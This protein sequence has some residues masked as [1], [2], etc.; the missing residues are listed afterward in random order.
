MKN[1][2]LNVRISELTQ[3]RLN[4]LMEDG[5]NKSEVVELALEMAQTLV[6]ASKSTDE[7]KDAVLLSL[8][9][10]FIKEFKQII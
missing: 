10:N 5:L 6:F 3:K 7:N 1:E 9:N 8:M 2:N 4:K